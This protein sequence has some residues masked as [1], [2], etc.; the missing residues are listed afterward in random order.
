MINNLFDDAYSMMR[1]NG[2]KSIYAFAKYFMPEH[3]RY[4]PSVAHHEVYKILEGISCKRNCKFA[5]AAP[6]DFGKS[7]LVTLI[8]IVWSICY[9][10]EKF[11]VIISN[12]SSQAKQILEN[13]RRELTENERLRSA[14]PHIFEADGR[15]KPPRWRQDDIVTR[16]GVEVLALGSGQQIR[17]RRHGS[18]RP[19]L[20]IADD[21][22][23][24]E[25]TFSSESRD[26]LKDWFSKS[27]IR[28]GSEST[29]ILYIG[30]LYHP[31]CLLSEYVNPELNPSWSSRV[32]KAIITWPNHI[33]LWEKWRNIYNSRDKFEDTSG[34][35]A[36]LRYY[37]A[38]KQ[39]MDE[40]AVLLWPERHS[41]CNLMIAREENELSFMSE[42]QNSPLDSKICIFNADELHYWDG[43]YQCVEN[44]L[45][46]LGD[47]AE[48]FG[49]CDPSLGGQNLKGDYSAIVILVRDKRD[50]VLYVIE[51]DIKRRT[52]TETID[53]ILA[54]CQ[55]YKFER[56]AV[57]TNQFQK[58][59]YDQLVERARKQ[60][61]YAPFEQVTNTSDKV[62]RIQALQPLVKNGTIKFAKFLRLLLEQMRYFPKGKYDDGLDAL[63][64]AVQVA[65]EKLGVVTVKILGEDRD[66]D[67][68]SDY[69]K[70]FGWPPIC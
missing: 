24:P 35:E 43:I 28:A 23:S 61:K 70:S 20:I 48:F 47:N 50:G 38:N 68:Y 12:T 22:E 13:I 42:L 4:L 62:K 14:F 27:V 8:Y 57:E 55:R 18:A 36:A 2:E 40:G 41:L 59:L 1:S 30:N 44:L 66:N 10:N 17:G 6:R 54:Y 26:K 31:Y 33:D 63:E 9:G 29:N 67:W 5:I 58:M 69:Q 60:S 7:T 45:H 16:N 46:A 39:A 19:T 25:N 49:S 64:M 15:P 51:A 56:F 65:E 3:L 21:V 52:P 11:I 53:D 32:Y 34:L 37:E